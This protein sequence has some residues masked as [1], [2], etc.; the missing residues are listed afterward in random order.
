MFLKLT[1]VQFQKY[2]TTELLLFNHDDFVLKF[3]LTSFYLLQLSAVTRD[4]DNAEDKL[5]ASE[6]KL[7]LLSLNVDELSEKY[8]RTTSELERLTEQ[9]QNQIKSGISTLFLLLPW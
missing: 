4:K 8:S 1:Y 6:S 3:T 7:K 9:S 2:Q 5:N